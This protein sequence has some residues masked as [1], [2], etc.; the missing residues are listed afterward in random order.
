MNGE[1]VLACRL[2]VAARNAINGGA[3]SFEKLPYENSISFVFCPRKTILGTGAEY[4]AKDPQQW[5]EKLK[6]EGVTDVFMMMPYV[7]KD[8]NRL[9]F[10]NTSG[11]T[12]F[13]RMKNGHVLRFVP[14]W[15]ADN[16]NRCWNVIIHEEFL[17]EAPSQLP[18]FKDNTERFKSVLDNIAKFAEHIG[19]EQFAGL[20]RKGYDVLN[21]GELPE[22]IKGAPDL[23][24]DKLRLFM[25]ADISDV[26]G[27]MG[28][29]NDSP[30]AKAAE[31]GLSEDYN[32]LSDALLAQNRLALMYAVNED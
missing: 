22:D 11:C 8:R 4:V 21:G 7:I 13:A 32:K 17:D 6:A 24:E 14:Q 9:G 23:P 2:T 19:F 12:I 3:F 5:Y 10:V 27:A 28:S 29:W 15:V 25:A 31:M 16:A 18:T 30:P 1:V 26:F 20:F